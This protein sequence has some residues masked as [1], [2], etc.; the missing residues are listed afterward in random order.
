MVYVTPRPH[1]S[2]CCKTE[3]DAIWVTTISYFR[4]NPKKIRLFTECLLKLELLYVR[5]SFQILRTFLCICNCEYKNLFYSP[6][7]MKYNT[8][9]LAHPRYYPPTYSQIFRSVP[10][11]PQSRRPTNRQWYSSR[12]DKYVQDININVQCIIR[13]RVQTFPASPA[14]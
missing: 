4:N 7:V 13:S 1:C 6:A 10:L 14:F 9:H 8:Q 2:N 5:P 3:E 12:S 11:T